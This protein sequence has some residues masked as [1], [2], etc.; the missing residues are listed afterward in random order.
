MYDR[1]TGSTST[2][3]TPPARECEWKPAAQTQG[4]GYLFHR[5][6]GW[7]SRLL[8][9]S[10]GDLLRLRS[11]LAGAEVEVEHWLAAIARDGDRDAYRQQLAHAQADAAQFRYQLAALP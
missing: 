11:L 9:R 7:I 4:A 8:T 6:S 3:L 10:E 1:Q 5:P 2:R